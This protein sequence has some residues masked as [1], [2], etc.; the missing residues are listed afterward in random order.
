MANEIYQKISTLWVNFM[1]YVNTNFVKEKKH[2]ANT[3][4]ALPP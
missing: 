4:A 1:I 3:I 2:K